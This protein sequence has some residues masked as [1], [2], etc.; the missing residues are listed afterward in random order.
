MRRVA[1]VVVAAAAAL[2]GYAKGYKFPR[3]FTGRERLHALVFGIEPDLCKF[4]KRNVRRGMTVLDIGGNVGLICR[5]FAK[6]VGAR[7]KVWSFEPDPYTRGFLEYNLQGYH[8][9]S[10]SPIAISDSNNVAHLY[11]HSGSGTGN[12]LLAISDTSGT[13]DV[14][15]LTLDKFLEL[16]NQLQPDVIKIDVEGAEPQV[17]AGMDV[18][19]RQ[20]PNVVIITEFCPANLAN[21]LN[22]PNEFFTQLV[23]L[24]LTMELILN[25]GDT[26]PVHDCNELLTLM[27]RRIY[28]NLACRSKKQ[29][30]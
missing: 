11:L 25:N 4:I 2:V 16:E 17:F 14:E 24:G 20:F 8:N 5:I 12:S 1:R 15:C 9:V 22:K 19:I 18:T 3:Y 21:G 29:Y 28:C 10:V 27:G 30:A 7:G 23:N 6:K 26:Y 13:V